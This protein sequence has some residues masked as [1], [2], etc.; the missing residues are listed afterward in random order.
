[1]A[2]SILD[3]LVDGNVDSVCDADWLGRR[4]EK[5]AAREL[6]LVRLF[7]RNGKI[8]RNVYI[9]KEDGETTEIDLL[10]ITA[11]GIFVLESKNYSGWI[12]GSESQHKW[13]VSF[14]NGAKER[15]YNPIKQNRAHCKWLRRYLGDGTPL[16]P[17]V[18]FSER[19]ELKKIMVDSPDTRVVKRDRLHAAIR[20]IWDDSPDA[21]SKAGVEEVYSRLRSLTQVTKKQKKGHI[22]NI[23]QR[24]ERQANQTEATTFSV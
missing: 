12:F 15:F 14:P 24:F 17:I 3:S 11:K 5:L 7:G 8:L 1:M 6:N 4:G 10:F 23:E 20:H 18:V 13:T 21:L 22:E 16:F 9:P 19:C 2:K